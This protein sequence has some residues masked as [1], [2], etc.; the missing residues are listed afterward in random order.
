MKCARYHATKRNIS[1]PRTAI[2]D[3]VQETSN[4]FFISQL[5]CD[6]FPGHVDFFVMFPCVI[7]LTLI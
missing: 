1:V 5:V 7:M 2:A 6:T 3:G 4:V